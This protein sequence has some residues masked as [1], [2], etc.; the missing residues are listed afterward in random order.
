MQNNNLPVDTSAYALLPVSCCIC[1]FV[2][3]DFRIIYANRVFARNWYERRQKNFIGAFLAKDHVIEADTLASLKRSLT[4]PQAVNAYMIFAN[5]HVRFEPFRLPAK[6]LLGL[7]IVHMTAVEEMSARFRFLHNIRQL[8]GVAILIRRHDD[9]HYEALYVSKEYADMMESTVEETLHIMDGATYK[10]TTHADDW[11]LVDYTLKNHHAPDGGMDIQIRKVTATG[12]VVWCNVHFAFIYYIDENYVYVTYSDITSI[13]EREA[14]TK[15]LYESSLEDLNA[16]AN[17]NLLA[18]RFNL[19]K[20]MVEE[21]HGS[22]FSETDTIEQVMEKIKKRLNETF[23][24]EEDR[25]RFVERFGTPQLMANYHNGIR[26]VTDV[27]FNQRMNGRRCFVKYT[28]TLR[29]DPVSGE[30]ISFV[31]EKDFNDEMV[32]QTILHKALVDQYDMITYIVDGNYGVVIGDATRIGSGSI[33]PKNRQGNYND[34]I[35]NEVLPFVPDEEKDTVEKALYLEKV[36]AELATNQS[37][38]TDIS[39]KLNG[40]IF[41]KRF[42]FYPVSREADFYILLKADTT[43][44]RREQIA[45]NEQLR[46]ALNEAKQASVAKTA[47][48]SSMSH[49]IRTPMNAIIGLDN[50]A[51]KEPNISPRTKD[52]LEKIGASARHLLGLINDILDMSRI[53]SGRMTLKNE[54]FSF[55]AIL[56]QINTMIGAQCRDRKLNYLPEIIG[57]VDEYYIGDSMKL[58]QVLINILGNAVKFTPTG[59]TVTF[60]IER[61]QKFED[62]STL[63]FIVKDTGIGMDKDYLPKIFDAFTQEDLTTTNVYGGSGLGM[64]ITKSIVEMMNGNISVKSE[65]GVGSEFTVNVTFKNSDRTLENQ[66]ILPENLSVLVIDDDPI[67]LEHA[68]IVLD[69]LGIA[70]DSCQSGSEGLRMINLRHVRRQ[71]YNL[72]LI[73]LKMP[74]LD[75]FE[76]AKAIRAQAGDNIVLII[77]TAYNW[78][79][80]KDKT[81]DI[82]IDGFISKPLFAANVL[83]ELEKIFLRRQNENAAHKKKSVELTGR[84]V[85]LAEDMFVNAEIMKEVLNMRKVLVEHAENGKLAVEMFSSSP[86]N[87]YDAILMDVRMPIMDGLQATEKIRALDRADAKTVPIIAMTAN[88]F[89][90]DVQRSLQAGMNAHLSKPVEPEQLYKTLA[91]FMN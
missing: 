27:F 24:L 84:R 12:K 83:E 7:L 16:V 11:E 37:Y 35:Q 90:E 74:G 91:E 78:D 13:K 48:L 45:R 87:H 41:Y 71:D 23:P 3:E 2:D 81:P 17:E 33:F 86:P 53:E 82:K 5:L 9:G 22:E 64:A 26:T 21:C 14:Q 40:E 47:F 69:E 44:V 15:A 65:K 73:D 59:G 32:N 68:R 63:R 79:M 19:T 52:H 70:S 49:E 43:A 31:T 72:I 55:G 88:A 57:K 6:N 4:E 36:R 51:L 28:L 89:D 20:F 67:A 10:A 54:E 50:I 25:K 62:K 8:G 42:V 30:M 80:L 39:C 58:K 75:G 34:Y 66:R 38:V 76:T 77:C 85:L 1:E 61:T 18:F 56:E 46:L 60:S 29:E